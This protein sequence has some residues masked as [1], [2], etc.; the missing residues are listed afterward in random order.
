MKVPEK[1]D[2]TILLTDENDEAK[3]M[4]T[5]YES[6]QPNLQIWRETVCLYESL[7]RDLVPR[8]FG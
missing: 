7:D 3:N 2:W 5:V 1:V 6:G 8:F 4:K